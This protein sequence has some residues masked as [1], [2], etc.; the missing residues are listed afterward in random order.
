MSDHYTLDLRPDSLRTAAKAVSRLAEH[1][2]TKGATVRGTPSEIGD[3]WTGKAA[4]SIKAEMTAL[5]GHMRSFSEKLHASKRALD[6][7]ADH[8]DD[9]VR[10]L[11]GLNRQWQQ[12]ETDYA[13]AVARADDAA[14]S[15]TTS[16]RTGPGQVDQDTLD[17][18]GRTRTSARSA[19]SAARTTTQ[20][21]L[22]TRF[23]DLREQLRTWTRTAGDELTGSV[24][25]PVPP[26]AV[27][28]YQGTGAFPVHL[29]HSALGATMRLAQQFDDRHV[30]QRLE[31]DGR[32]AAEH[33]L[34]SRGDVSPDLAAE[35]ARQMN[36][37]YF[38]HGFAADLDPQRLSSLLTTYDNLQTNDP[39][40][41]AQERTR[42]QD[43]LV[44]ALGTMIGTAT[45]G[46]GELALPAGFATRWSSAMTATTWMEDADGS[47]MPGQAQRLA[48][49]MEQGVWGTD[50]L[51]SVGADLY[52]YERSHDGDPVWQPKLGATYVTGPDGLPRVDVMV[53]LM[54]ALSHNPE[55]SQR[56]FEGGGTGTLEVGG[57]RVQVSERMR[58]LIQDR[59]WDGMT[60]P[61]NGGNL[62]DA[63]KAA[64]TELRGRD[65]AGRTSAELASQM[66]A[67]IG[68]RTGDGQA[69]G[70]LGMGSHQGWKMWEG[71]RQDVADIT[72][73]Y[74]ADLMRIGRTGHSDAFDGGFVVEDDD[75]YFGAGAPYGARIDR[76]LMQRLLGT[77][78]ENDGQMDTVLAG[79]AAAT[80]QR[81]GFALHTSVDDGS[82]PPAPVAVLLGGNIPA[83]SA[84]TNEGAMALGWVLNGGYRGRLDQE[85][86]ER[87]QAEARQALFDTFTSLPGVGPAG[88]WSKFAFDQVKDHV[89][90]TIGETHPTASGDYSHMSG[91]EKEGLQHLVLNQM[92][93][94]GYFDQSYVDEANGGP[95]GSRYAAPPAGAVDQGPPPA[96]RFDDPSFDEWH[97]LRY[98][99]DDF[100]NSNVYVPFNESMNEGLALGGSS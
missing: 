94:E 51:S 76:E 77:L 80:H 85:D 66:F 32:Q 65:E 87:K 19:A 22:D 86:F 2:E 24:P 57:H 10:T 53:S 29:D 25:L 12:A 41:S 68:D 56:F 38:A 63:L 21:G 50:F 40:L 26:E 62:G 27:S 100:L 74:A 20:H 95:G 47:A 82:S 48:L 99:M 16:A 83:I 70:F 52:D 15:A 14:E 79:V 92:L 45:R 18:I 71:M 28:A 31:D 43:A 13:A 78:G 46:T 89:S 8:Y 5:G 67:V 1:S 37:P 11:A 81:L 42:R 44:T 93:A 75:T 17:S 39:D 59:G 30:Q 55:A 23:A 6:T 35:I 61:T 49:L 90:E 96:F 58:Y 33:L 34:A 36:N 60:D 88:E 7:L 91:T 97:R 69:D 98:P 73:E 64:T 9:A 3:R 84:A 4:T 54:E 72:A